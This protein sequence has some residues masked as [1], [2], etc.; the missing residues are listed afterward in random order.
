MKKRA[1]IV[2]EEMKDVLRERIKYA[3]SSISYSPENGISVSLT[4]ET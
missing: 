1:I 2:G 4:L 3:N